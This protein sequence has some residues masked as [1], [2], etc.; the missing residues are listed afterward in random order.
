MT[1]SNL[2]SSE[3]SKLIKERIVNFE[4]DADPRQRA[5]LDQLAGA[6]RA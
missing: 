3:V 1:T 5:Q 4:A 6:L 2:N